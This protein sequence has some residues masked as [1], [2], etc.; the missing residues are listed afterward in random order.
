[1]ALVSSSEAPEVMAGAGIT[2]DM[3]APDIVADEVIAL[4]L[5]FRN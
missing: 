4:T 5:P 1:L 2:P 3:L